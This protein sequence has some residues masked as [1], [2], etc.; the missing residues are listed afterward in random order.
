M[1]IK[2][3]EELL[4]IKCDNVTEDEVGSLIELLENELNAANRLGVEGIGLSAIQVGVRKNIAIVRLKDISFNLVNCTINQAYDPAIFRQ[5]GCL[6]FPGRVE[7]TI[8]FQE[9]HV[10]DNLVYPHNFI[11]TGLLSVICQHEIDHLNGALFMDRVNSI[12]T[13]S[14]KKNKLGPNDLCICGKVDPRTKH[15]KKFKKCCGK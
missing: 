15:P 11:A 10:V 14:R 5:E 12:N 7:D 2:N 3:D 13:V 6:S 9:I 4:R 8:R 1:I